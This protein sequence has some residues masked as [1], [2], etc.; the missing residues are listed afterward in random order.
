MLFNDYGLKNQIIN[1]NDD[2]SVTRDKINETFKNYKEVS[3]QLNSQKEYLK[4][5]ITGMWEKVFNL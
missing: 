4:N 2:W 1:V 5:E 3:E